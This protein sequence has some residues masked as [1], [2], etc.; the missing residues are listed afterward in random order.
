[1][2]A[3][4]VGGDRGR[5]QDF[6]SLALLWMLQSCAWR[7]TVSRSSTRRLADARLRGATGAS[8]A[9]S[10]QRPTSVRPGPASRGD[11]RARVKHR[12]R[13]MCGVRSRASARSFVAR[14]AT[15]P[16]WRSIWMACRRSSAAS[17]RLRAGS[18]RARR[19]RTAIWRQGLVNARQ[20]GPWGK[21][22]RETP[23]R[24]SY[25]AT[26]SSQRAAGSAASRR[27]AT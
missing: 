10:F 15:S 18:H 2:R 14:R 13:P 25:H 24:S 5:E 4:I 23:S 1:M 7:H 6:P 20:R 3:V 8:P 16:P 26:V 21:P 19:S 9:S 12:R 11:F 22:L 27:T 17:M